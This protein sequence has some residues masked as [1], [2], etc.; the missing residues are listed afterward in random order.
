M[1]F[2]EWRNVN[3]GVHRMRQ[4]NVTVHLRESFDGWTAEKQNRLLEQLIVLAGCTVEDVTFVGARRG[5][6]LLYFIFPEDAARRLEQQYRIGLDHTEDPNKPPNSVQNEIVAEIL[7]KFNVVSVRSDIEN[8]SPQVL[9][10][11]KL[12]PPLFVL[13]H[14][15]SG[16][17]ES[18]GNLPDILEKEFCC[19][20]AIP[21]Y[22]SSFLSHNKPLYHLQGKL[23]NFINNRSFRTP[24]PVA[25]IGHSMGGVISRA[26]L[27]ESIRDEGNHYANQ[28]KLFVSVA[29]PLS[30]TWLGTLAEKIPFNFSHIKQAA[31]LSARSDTLADLNKWWHHWRGNY[32]KFKGQV[33]T[34]YSTDDDVVPCNSAIGDDANAICIT[35]E[36]HTSIVKPRR[37]SDE[38]ALTLVRLAY[39]AGIEPAE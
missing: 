12:Q 37:P 34:I 2:Y 29:S 7:K 1:P 27:I 9:K 22:D 6:I 23:T 38:V 17:R 4:A 21:E 14:G 25:I 5:C 33:R 20:V 24:R 26:S 3:S 30:G 11:K 16:S 13:V 35:N 15:W 36:T 19:E 32:P 31:Q 18:F 10:S 28:T 39:Q 8:P